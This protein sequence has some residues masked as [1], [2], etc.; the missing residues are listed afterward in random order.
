MTWKE[1]KEKYE[2]NGGQEDDNITS[3]TTQGEDFII[4]RD[5][6]HVGKIHLKVI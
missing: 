4:E 5:G 3:I 6:P 1:F 2:K